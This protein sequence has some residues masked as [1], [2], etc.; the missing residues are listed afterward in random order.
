MCLFLFPLSLMRME[1]HLYTLAN[2][3]AFALPPHDLSSS[4]HNMM[5]QNGCFHL[6]QTLH[7]AL[8]FVGDC[9]IES[10]LPIVIPGFDVG[11]GFLYKVPYHVN[12]VIKSGINEG[13]TSIFV[14]GL[15]V[16]IGLFYEVLHRAYPAI[17]S[18]P[19]ERC[20]SI[21]LLGLNVGVGGLYEVLHCINMV[22]TSS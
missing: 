8:S 16:S 10:R 15:D 11:I 20:R 2:S 13:V 18:S 21:V 9:Y 4:C 1:S 5:D 17:D 19:D 14:L 22:A 7:N 6:G 12:M 3:M